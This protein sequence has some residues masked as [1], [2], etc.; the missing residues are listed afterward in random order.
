[1][2][3]FTLVE[4]VIVLV[5]MSSLAAVG[6]ASFVSYNRSQVVSVAVQN[7]RTTLYSARSYALAQSNSPTQ[8]LSGVCQCPLGQSFV[9]YQVVFCC[10][11]GESGSCPSTCIVNDSKEH[12][13]LNLLCSSSSFTLESDHFPTGVTVDGTSSSR[14][15]LFHAISGAVDGS[16]SVII[17]NNLGQS[18]TVT[19][20]PLGVVQ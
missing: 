14:S 19:V 8:C 9:G 13:E 12:Y 2:K 6:L 3:G 15:F 1:M 4:L 16:G 7:A 20:S 11:T 10:A 17:T 5:I 18:G